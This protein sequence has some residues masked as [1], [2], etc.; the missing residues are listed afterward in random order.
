MM[1]VRV[2]QDCRWTT[3]VVAGMVFSK[4]YFNA[5][6]EGTMAPQVVE[7]IEGCGMLEVIKPSPQ[8]SPRAE[9][10][11]KKGKKGQ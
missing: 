11:R 2:H 5:M 4:R 7:E 1:Q 8:P 3:V 10:G 6:D 9:R